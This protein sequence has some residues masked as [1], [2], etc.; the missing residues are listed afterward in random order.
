MGIIAERKHLSIMQGMIVT[1][2]NALPVMCSVKMAEP[3]GRPPPEPEA[4]PCSL[5][6]SDS[7]ESSPNMLREV[8]MTP[9]RGNNWHTSF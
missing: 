4:E 2:A 3:V 5:T 8:L 1:D 9:V 6:C 7:S